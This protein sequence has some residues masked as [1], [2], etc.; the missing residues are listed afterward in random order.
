MGLVVSDR[1]A[2]P[3]R[4]EGI[5]RS[6]G[7]AKERPTGWILQQSRAKDARARMRTEH[8]SWEREANHRAHDIENRYGDVVRR[9]A[10]RLATDGHATIA[11]TAC[12]AVEARIL[13]FRKD[14]VLE[15][16]ARGKRMAQSQQSSNASVGGSG[17]TR[18]SFDG[19]SG[20]TLGRLRSRSRASDRR[21]GDD[22]LCSAAVAWGRATR[23]IAAGAYRVAAV[24]PTIEAW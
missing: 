17:S 2:G 14:A 20:R 21:P 9:T 8:E 6:G 3:F 22:R 10:M 4:R 12:G 16:E 23:L 7:G 5:G 24:A 13:M 1:G 11:A 19:L 18:A 15:I